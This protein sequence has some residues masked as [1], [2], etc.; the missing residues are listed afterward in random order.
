MKQTSIKERIINYF[1]ETLELL[2]LMFEVM[3]DDI[4]KI[5]K[6]EKQ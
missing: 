5:I 2:K 4:I 3:R 6:R 1:K